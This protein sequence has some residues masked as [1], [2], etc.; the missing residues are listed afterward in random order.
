MFD[1]FVSYPHK[2]AEAV[3][4]LVM[5][6]RARGL[7]VWFDEG[8]VEDFGSIQRAIEQGLSRSKTLVAWY[9]RSYPESLACPR[10]LGAAH[11]AGS[12]DHGQPRRRDIRRHSR[13]RV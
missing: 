8:D 10:W 2:D 12:N 3:R 5:A 11:G 6:L 13:L 7:E 9:S 4:P 1:V